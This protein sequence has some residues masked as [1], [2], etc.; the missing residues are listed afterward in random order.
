MS[1][2][3]TV[4]QECLRDLEQGMA[5]VE[6]CLLR[7]S[8]HAAQLEPILLASA[9]LA[10][11][12]AA[13]L[14]PA[15]KARVRNRLI[16]Q[17]YAHPRR[18][19]RSRFVFLRLAASLAVAM[20]A[21]LTAG[22]V[23]AQRALPGEAFY[24]WKLASE[25]TWKTVS[26]DPLGTDLAIA[27]RRLNELIAVRNNPILRAQTLN[28]YL[29]VTDRLRS[30]MNPANEARILSVLDVQ[31]EELSQL[32]ILPEGLAPDLV[33]PFEEP[34]ATPVETPLPALETPQVNSTELPQIL[35]TLEVV[36]ETLPTVP[37]PPKIIPTLEIPPPIP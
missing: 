3:E 33:P 36:P 2:F 26:P 11:G 7:H 21:L 35:P 12:R 24:V 19:A 34:T 32:D 29:E 10:R 1:E 28:A 23:Y 31:V 22:T 37:D 8:K 9:Y 20:L 6:E 16:Q 13:R 25:N 18:P 14:S 30:Q 4:L 27:E 15:F 17:M 5:N